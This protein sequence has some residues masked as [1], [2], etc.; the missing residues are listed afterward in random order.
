M[1][2]KYLAL[3]KLK[4]SP[5]SL[6][7]LKY[8]KNSLMLLLLLFGKTKMSKKEYSA[9]CLEELVKNFPKVEEVDSEEKLTFCYVEILQLPNLNYFNM[10]IRLLLE[11][12][13][14]QEKEVQLLV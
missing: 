7:T 2:I 13:I 3:N 14:H 12:F 10:F 11:V 1:N 6:K 4:D 9:N 5:N 8:M